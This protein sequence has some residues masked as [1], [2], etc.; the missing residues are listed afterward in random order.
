MI[1]RQSI[2][3]IIAT[4]R[5]HGWTLRRVL[6]SPPSLEMLESTDV[7]DGVP[8]ENSPIDAMWFSRRARPGVETWELRAIS[9]SPFALLENVPNETS[10]GDA[11]EV[12]RDAERRLAETIIKPSAADRG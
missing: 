8:L 12:L 10:R 2:A 1:D 5:K 7:F 11:A 6:L 3:D 4:Y 9:L